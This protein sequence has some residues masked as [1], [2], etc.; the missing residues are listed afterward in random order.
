[1]TKTATDPLAADPPATDQ[2]APDK[3]T[4]RASLKRERAALTESVWAE[5][6]AAIVSHLQDYV[7]RRTCT[8]VALYAPLVARR[9][10][11]VSALAPWLRARGVHVAYPLMSGDELGFAWVQTADQLE[12]RGAF[13]QPLATCPHVL[14]GELD[15][16]VVPALAATATG[17]RLGYGSGFYDKVLPAFCPPGHAVCVVFAA[18]LRSELPVA[19]HD[20]AC[21]GVVTELGWPRA[22]RSP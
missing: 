12:E 4:L 11:D 5:Q 3:R 13:A 9:E 8:R 15:L 18:Q 16:V 6:S 14:A 22:V 19:S 2:H 20:H 7:T 1:M 10:V 17:Y 21:D